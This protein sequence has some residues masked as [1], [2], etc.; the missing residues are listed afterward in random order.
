MGKESASTTRCQV[1]NHPAVDD[2]D[3]AVRAGFE[4]LGTISRQFGVHR[5]A[6]RNHRAAHMHLRFEDI[7][8]GD[9]DE[10]YTWIVHRLTR[11]AQE[12]ARNKETI[13]GLESDI[14][15]LELKNTFTNSNF[16]SSELTT[17]L[18]MLHFRSIPTKSELHIR[19]RKLSKGLHPDH[20]NGDDTLQRNINWAREVILKE[21]K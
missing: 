3:D 6:L 4:D 14:K 2:I 11:M 16:Q 13:N 18:G 7:R 17:A 9:Y 10:L 12:L 8:Y 15:Q 1:C 21:I 5:E 20:Q 19:Y